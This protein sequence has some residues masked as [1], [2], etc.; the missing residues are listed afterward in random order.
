[1][2]GLFRAPLGL[3]GRIFAI[4]LLTILIEFAVSTVLYERASHFSVRDDEA[5][6]LA[7][8][9]VISR[10]IMAEQPIEHRPAMAGELTTDR[11]EV[12]WK[13]AQPQLPPIAPS[14]DHIYHQVVTW[15]PQLAST[16]LRLRLTS[17]GRQAAIVGG[18][19]LPD[20]S[21]LYFRT[22]EPVQQLNLATERVLLALIP[23]MGLIL[24]GGLMVRQMLLPLRRL[25]VAADH[26]GSENAEEV[27]EAGPAEVRRV[28]H[29]F[30]RMQGRIR[31]LIADRTQALAA[32]GHDMRTPLAR[33]RLRADAI[34]DPALRA[35]VEADVAEMEAMIASVLAYL[36]G[37]G[38]IEKPVPADLAVLCAT[39][40]DERADLGDSVEY[41]GPRHLEMTVRPMAMKRAV[42]NLVENAL[43]HAEH[44]CVR[45][46]EEEKRV[47]IRVEDD[48]PGIPEESM[49]LVLQPFVRLDSARTRDTVGFGLGLPIVARVAEA[50]GG[51]LTLSNR[52]EGGLRAEIALP[53]G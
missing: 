1:M 23:A 24:I 26:V 50:E 53:R 40:C 27:P 6:R 31:R 10:K 52:P 47:L 18:L 2:S 19:R 44:V 34:A 32:V 4:L 5:R 7:E 14:L 21:W 39:L 16:D 28:V 45:L 25:A 3:I 43:H 13:A 33:L 48:G 36:G 29:A 11:Y 8:H 37:E 9:L 22:R 20:R 17:P 35:A 12:H 30:N 46:I 41:D 49:E 42:V 15:E 38:D 51:A